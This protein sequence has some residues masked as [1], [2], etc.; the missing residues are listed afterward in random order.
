MRRLARFHRN[1]DS[2]ADVLE[3]DYR[4]GFPIADAVHGAETR[5]WDRVLHGVANVLQKRGIPI[6]YRKVAEIWHYPTVSMNDQMSAL[7]V[8]KWL[9]SALYEDAT[10]Y[11]HYEYSDRHFDHLI[12]LARPYRSYHPGELDFDRAVDDFIDLEIKR[13]YPK[14]RRG[15][16]KYKELHGQVIERA[17]KLIEDQVSAVKEEENR[18][19]RHRYE[20]DV[21]KSLQGVAGRVR[22]LRM[23]ASHVNAVLGPTKN[24][25][26]AL[27][28]ADRLEQK[29][30]SINDYWNMVLSGQEG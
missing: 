2:S 8:W 21:V 28:E 24:V 12:S 27:A 7:E 6:D 26:A 13:A 18:K 23:R 14:V 5:P 29:A 9:D 22:W 3:S 15:T 19:R 1:P 17:R 30:A 10:K 4:E 16:K 11:P 25:V 20:A